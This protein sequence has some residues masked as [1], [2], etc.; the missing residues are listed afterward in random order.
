VPEVE[1][2]LVLLDV[3]LAGSALRGNRADNRRCSSGV[4]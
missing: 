1:P 4:N 3:A 2:D